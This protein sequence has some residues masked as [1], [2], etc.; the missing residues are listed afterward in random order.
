MND[1]RA[2]CKIMYQGNI[3]KA[4]WSPTYAENEELA[5][6]ALA[7]LT[8]DSTDWLLEQ[9]DLIIQKYRSS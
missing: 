4:E 7:L 9:E 1:I 5:L 8:G 2:G 6:R 3:L